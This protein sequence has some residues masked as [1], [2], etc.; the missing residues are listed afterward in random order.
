MNSQLPL[1]LFPTELSLAE[2]SD[3]TL[4]LRRYERQI[5]ELKQELAM[6]DALRCEGM[7]QGQPSIQSNE[8]CKLHG[9][10]KLQQAATCWRGGKA[11]VNYD[12]LSDIEIREMNQLAKDFLQ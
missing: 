10:C 6:R 4:L 8:R 7:G 11:R 3:P 9:R 1:L 12:D 5:K 2:S